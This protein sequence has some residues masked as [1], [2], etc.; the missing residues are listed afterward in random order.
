MFLY[1]LILN[2]WTSPPPSPLSL[3]PDPVHLAGNPGI[4]P[5]VVSQ[6]TPLTP[7]HNTYQLITAT[8]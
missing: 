3:P 5:W 6:C 8:S 1:K 7:G 2:P 4:D